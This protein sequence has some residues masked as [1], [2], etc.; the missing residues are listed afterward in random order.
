MYMRTQS[1]MENPMAQPKAPLYTHTHTH[2][3]T[4]Y[5]VAEA[6][7]DSEDFSKQNFYFPAWEREG[8]FNRR[9][10]TLHNQCICMYFKV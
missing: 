1:F 9:Y 10:S 7:G 2:T 8:A 4:P 5:G 3:H 6:L